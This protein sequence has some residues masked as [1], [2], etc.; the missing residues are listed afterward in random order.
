MQTRCLGISGSFV[1]T[2]HKHAMG[3][4][5]LAPIIILKHVPT[6]S[7]DVFLSLWDVSRCVCVAPLEYV[8]PYV[9]INE[10][11]FLGLFL[12]QDHQHQQHATEEFHVYSPCSEC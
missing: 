9:F 10:H 3:Y 2:T 6:G 4:K 7:L 12:F 11:L 5:D 8:C 1:W